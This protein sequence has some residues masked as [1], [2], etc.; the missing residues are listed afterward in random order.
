M[1]TRPAP[2]FANLFMAEM[3]KKLLNLG[4]SH[5]HYFKRFI[6][7]IW[8]ASELQFIQFMEERNSSTKQLSSPT[9]MS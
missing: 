5:I 7:D 8:T 9:V 3:G 1:G 4:Q 2:T 6:D